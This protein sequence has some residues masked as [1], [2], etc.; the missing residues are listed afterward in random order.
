MCVC[1]RKS[2]VHI[3]ALIRPHLSSFVFQQN[4][5]N[6]LMCPPPVPPKPK[7]EGGLHFPSFMV[8]R[9]FKIVPCLTVISLSLCVSVVEELVDEEAERKKRKEEY[10]R[11]YVSPWER[12]MK[13]NEEL[14]ATM[15]SRMPGP[16]QIHAELPLYKSFNRYTLMSLV[17]GG[18]KKNSLKHR[19]I[20]ST[21]MSNTNNNSTIVML[22]M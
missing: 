15:R 5:E 16:I 7:A 20:P 14:M 12:A 6:L 1:V 2:F 3:C 11:T 18:G 8:F 22:I 21:M 17:L 13:G 4:L 10:V 19:D 9:A